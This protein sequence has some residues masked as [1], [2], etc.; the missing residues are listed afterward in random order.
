MY[1][2]YLHVLAEQQREVSRL[3]DMNKEIHSLTEKLKTEEQWFKHR[4]HRSADDIDEGIEYIIKLCKVLEKQYSNDQQ[5][6]EKEIDSTY[7]KLY[8]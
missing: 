2:E 4:A 1:S 3:R 5:V 7:K 6:R 8:S